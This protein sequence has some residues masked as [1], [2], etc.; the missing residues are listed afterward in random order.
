MSAGLDTAAVVLVATVCALKHHEG[1]V[2]SAVTEPDADAVERGLPNLMKHVEN[3]EAFGEEPVVTLNRFH[4]DSD[5]EIEV[6]PCGRACAS[7]RL[8][9]AVSEAYTAGGAGAVA[10]AETVMRHAER[11]R[12]PFTPLYSWT[13]PIKEKLEKV[14]HTMYG[15]GSVLW[16]HQAEKDLD[17][18]CQ[19]CGEALPLCIAK[20]QSSLSDDPRSLGRPEGSSVFNLACCK[21]VRLGIPS[22]HGCPRE[23]RAPNPPA[24][25]T[26]HTG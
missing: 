21:Q 16:E 2:T 25:R 8:P 15:A 18:M 11:R 4:G 3:I 12:K 22:L 5:A 20:T 26:A 7:W 19:C 6:V 9:F 24:R 1:V 10:L 23:V 14:A 13:D 17:V